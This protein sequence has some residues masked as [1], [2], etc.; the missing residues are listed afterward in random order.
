MHKSYKNTGH[1]PG[2]YDF[3]RKGSFSRNALIAQG[4]KHR[5]FNI[6]FPLLILESPPNLI[7]IEMSLFHGYFESTYWY[8]SYLN[9]SNQ[10]GNQ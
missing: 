6:L 10:N 8:R 7:K 2:T 9:P 4:Q 5:L 3:D 1:V